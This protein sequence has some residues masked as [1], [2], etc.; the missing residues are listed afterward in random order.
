MVM[1]IGKRRWEVKL[2]GRHA[3][4]SKLGAGASPRPR[5]LANPTIPRALSGLRCQILQKKRPA[6][7]AGL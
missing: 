5:A 2:D 4:V 1:A 3:S 7:G 6:L